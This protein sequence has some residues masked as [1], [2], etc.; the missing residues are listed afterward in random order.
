MSGLTNM[1]ADGP[2]GASHAGA[3]GVRA[4][5]PASQPEGKMAPDPA[6]EE[7]YMRR[8]IA[9]AR[10]ATGW[11]NPNPLVG[12]V[13]VKDGR[14]IGE[15]CH[16]R[17]G[18]LH[19]ERN[20]LASCAESPAGATVYV[21]LEP[22][23]HTGKQPPCVDALIEA[24][25]A[26][27]VVG[28]RDPN[29]LVSGKGNARLRAAGIEVRED[30]LRGECD[31]LNPVFFHYIP[32][33]DPYVVAKWAMTA[34][35]KTATC[36]GDS[37]WVSGEAARAEV[38]EMR[39]RLASIMVGIGTV[40]ADDPLLTARRGEPSNQPLRIVCDSRLR[41]PLESQLVRTAG[42][43]PVLV[44]TAA[45]VDGEA[46]QAARALEGAGVQVLAVPGAD[47]EVDLSQLMGQLGARG[48][49]SVLLEGGGTLAWAAFEAG[50]VDEAVVYVAPKVAGGRDAKTPV[51]G[52]GVA[53]MA[54]AHA[55][56]RPQVGLV[57]D[58][59]KIV[60]RVDS[61]AGAGREGAPCSRA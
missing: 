25:V 51:S 37:R 28:S 8:A 42:E 59:V 17:Y 24:G 60:Y 43:S 48:V 61:G 9:L 23:N 41:I 18:Q 36:T 35:G 33:K 22:C 30:F 52:E 50:I 55:L 32:H 34:D 2:G 20:A 27:V 40:L 47:G 31:A 44:A 58:D 10:T 4:S 54:K 5:G 56:G 14:I 53:L 38:H 7:A 6:G 12:A 13:I 46:R 21:T 19:A 1:P 29:P 39:H 11:T 15:G 3:A 49:D 45:D 16:E 26:K 57:G